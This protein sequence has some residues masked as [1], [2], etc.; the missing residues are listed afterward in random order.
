MR[1]PECSAE[2]AEASCFCMHCGT[3]LVSADTVGTGH[4][5]TYGVLRPRPRWWPP[6]IPRGRLLILGGAALLLVA[7]ITALVVV[8]GGGKSSYI[9][10]ASLTP[11]G[12][13]HLCWAGL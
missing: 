6:A 5:A 1:C 2:N 10:V 4:Q 9:V 12:E 7:S 3:P 8:V 11:R 13:T